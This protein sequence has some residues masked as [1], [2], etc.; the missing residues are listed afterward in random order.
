MEAAES[1]AVIK[2]EDTRYGLA[3]VSAAWF[4]YPAE[5]LKVIGITGTKGK[6]TT[7]YMVKSI[8][9]QAG[10]R[11][12]LIGTI[13]AVIGEQAIPAKNTTPESYIVQEYF[14]KGRRPFLCRFLCISMAIAYRT[15]DAYKQAAFCHLSGIVYHLCDFQIR[16]SLHQ[17]IFQTFQ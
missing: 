13:E 2:V 7:T 9:E 14:Q 16:R 17:G 10:Y 6:T 8:L 4:H 3:L 11:V 12:G 1:A 5:K 15:F